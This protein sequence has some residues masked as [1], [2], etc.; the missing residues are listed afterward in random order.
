MYTAHC[1][2]QYCFSVNA[3]GQLLLIFFNVVWTLKLTS[4]GVLTVMTEL[5]PHE[6]DSTFITI[7]TKTAVT[8][9]HV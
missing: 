6:C 5:T 3:Y 2:W 7:V 4:N 1:F 8:K 9:F